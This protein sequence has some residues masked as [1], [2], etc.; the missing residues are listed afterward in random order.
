MSPPSVPTLA[1]P[2]PRRLRDRQAD[3]VGGAVCGQRGDEAVPGDE[4][5]ARLLALT[6][7]LLGSSER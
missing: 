4:A 3:G 1:A 7:D 5:D 2:V 6:A